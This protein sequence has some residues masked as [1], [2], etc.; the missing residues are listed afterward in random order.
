[1]TK[2]WLG[3]TA[4]IA[5]ATAGQAAA[6][7]DPF[8][9]APHGATER[10]VPHSWVPEDRELQFGSE[11]LEHVRLAASDAADNAECAVTHESAS[12]MVL[13]MTWPEVAPSG[14]PPS[15]MTLSRWD[16]QPALG[17]PLDRAPG[18]WFHPG[19]GMWQ[20]DSAGLGTHLTAA[21]AMDTRLVA[22]WIA[23]YIVTR[24]CASWVAGTSTADARSYAWRAWHACRSG[25][26]ED[27][28]HRA[29]GS[30]TAVDD[31][32]RLGGADARTCWF[33][34]AAHDCTFVDPAA[35]QGS[36]WW[37][38]ESAGR[39]PVTAPFYSLKLGGEPETELRYWL[40]ADSGAQT[41][42][43]ARRQFGIDARD[44]LRWGPGDGLCDLTEQRGEC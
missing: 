25:A 8:A 20:L 35:A 26:C 3:A 42:V 15:P 12:A 14:A 36:A 16:D 31:V 38:R 7:E 5:M 33:Q 23:P 19:I 1:M 29:L 43:T 34:G 40:A 4:V 18:L 22:G 37:A 39:S 27:T 30:V 24:Y 2:V 11:P 28:Y 32:G 41:D 10:P 21:E 17:D 6:D 13:A 9:P 44:G